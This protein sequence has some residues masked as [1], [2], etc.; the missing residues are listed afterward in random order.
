M[1][2]YLKI[3]TDLSVRIFCFEVI[4]L[5]EKR[6]KLLLVIAVVF[7]V[8]MLTITLASRIHADLR[9]RVY[10]AGFYLQETEV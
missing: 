6:K 8:N 10:P 7:A 1:Y 2:N 5:S 9:M 3:L 4:C